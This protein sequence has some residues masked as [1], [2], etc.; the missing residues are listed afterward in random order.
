MHDSPCQSAFKESPVAIRR[1]EFDPEGGKAPEGDAPS[2]CVW[3]SVER[4]E[5]TGVLG[6]P[7]R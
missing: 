1:L 6:K 7:L 2:G 4:G 3:D 5:S